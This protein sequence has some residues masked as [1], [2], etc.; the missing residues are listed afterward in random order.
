M[1]KPIL[2]IVIIVVLGI[3]YS[4]FLYQQSEYVAGEERYFTAYELYNATEK[5]VDLSPVAYEEDK[6]NLESLKDI[7]KREIDKLEEFRIQLISIST[8]IF[9]SNN[10]VYDY[11]SYNK[12]LKELEK[13]IEDNQEYY[14]WQQNDLMDLNKFI[15]KIEQDLY[16]IKL[17]ES[18]IHYVSSVVN[19]LDSTALK[20]IK[21]AKFLEFTS[22]SKGMELF[23]QIEEENERKR[24]EL[25]AEIE[26]EKE[27]EKLRKESKSNYYSGYSTYSYTT[28]NNSYDKYS[29]ISIQTLPNYSKY[30]LPTIPSQFYSTNTNPN[31]VQVDGYSKSNG[32]YVEPYMRTE[33]NNTI[34]DNFSTS[35]NLNPYTGRIGTI[36]V[37][38]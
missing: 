2:L 31:H 15:L 35:P 3:L 28:L 36:K 10:T 27:L 14:K 17:Y 6:Y 4:I 33:K 1:R 16:S 23:K 24:Q 32:T 9:N 18:D 37:K 25:I 20:Y 38:N 5:T 22:A 34:I 21:S 19:S 7:T 13:K 30:D 26:Y 11:D 29:N 8:L 12:T